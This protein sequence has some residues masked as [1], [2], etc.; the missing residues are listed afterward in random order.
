MERQVVIRCVNVKP[1]RSGI[2]ADRDAND[3][4]TV[5]L[6]QRQSRRLRTWIAVGLLR[7][8]DRE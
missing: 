5:V 1:N 2:A 3:T 8:L 7:M 6:E 4:R